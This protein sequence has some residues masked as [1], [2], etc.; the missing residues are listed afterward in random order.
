LLAGA[1]CSGED[2][3]HFQIGKR[4]LLMARQLFWKNSV[5]VHGRTSA[6]RRG[7]TLSPSARRAQ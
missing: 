7:G 5:L 4:N 2:A 6:A 1:A 3:D